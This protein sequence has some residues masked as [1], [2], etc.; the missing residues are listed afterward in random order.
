[1]KIERICIAGYRNDLRWTQCCVA[2]IRHWYPEIRITLLKDEYRGAYDTS[3]LETAW[4]VDIFDTSGR[5]FGWGMIKLEPLMAS[6]GE[7]ILIVDSDIL[8]LGPVLEEWDRYEE[9]FLVDNHYQPPG[10]V[11]AF[12]FSPDR[13]L[14]MDPEFILPDFVFNGGAVVALTG[15][16][17]R[18][19]F[20][21]FIAHGI[22]PGSLPQVRDQ[23]VFRNSEQGVL[24]YVVF[25]L[26]QSGR[27]T[28]RGLKMQRWAGFQPPRSLRIRN[29][30][31][32]SP[33]RFLLHYA[34][35][36]KTIFSANRNGHLLRY[37]EAAYYA[38]LPNGRVRRQ[39]DRVHR[40]LDILRKRKPWTQTI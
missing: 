25:K 1:M 30:H 22:G 26:A 39:H 23:K 18:S 35:P 20:D 17:N 11:D 24:N 2:S 7:R 37:F 8:F 38:R 40:L 31:S 19:D 3:E 10:N 9:D 13:L 5:V 16:L 36:K 33:Y 34:G 32:Q 28:V 27:L 6:P 15:V 12:Y 4:D 14:N 21:E 29:L